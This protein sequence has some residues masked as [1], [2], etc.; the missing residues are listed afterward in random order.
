[1]YRRYC[2]VSNDMTLFI[3]S[4]GGNY[5]GILI[6]DFERAWNFTN[7]LTDLSQP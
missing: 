6:L 3:F 1:M 7:T 2:Y 4:V 5:W